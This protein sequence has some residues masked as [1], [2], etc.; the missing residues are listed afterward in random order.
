M[1]AQNTQKSLSILSVYGQDVNGLRREGDIE[2]EI[3]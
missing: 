2:K 1:D 3:I